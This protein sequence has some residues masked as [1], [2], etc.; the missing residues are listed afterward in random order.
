LGFAAV[1]LGHEVWDSLQD[2][3]VGEG[4]ECRTGTPGGGEV[5]AGCLT[6]NDGV[7]WRE[8]S[9]ADEGEG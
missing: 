2:V 1:R 9:G 5:G 8:R 7:V 6:G 3:F 4:V